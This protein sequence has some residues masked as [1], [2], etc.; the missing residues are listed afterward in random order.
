MVLYAYFVDMMLSSQKKTD[1]AIKSFGKFSETVDTLHTVSGRPC[2]RV[3]AIHHSAEFFAESMRF[4]K[5]M[6]PW[7]S[8]SGTI[9]ID[10]LLSY[11]ALFILPHL[12]NTTE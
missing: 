10:R 2:N 12:C 8:C 1:P 7:T 6:Q 9:Q 11:E 5:Y 4:L 3:N